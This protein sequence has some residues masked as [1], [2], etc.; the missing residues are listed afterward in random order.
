MHS[1]LTKPENTTLDDRRNAKIPNSPFFF[2]F[3]HTSNWKAHSSGTMLSLSKVQ[4]KKKG[5]YW[6]CPFTAHSFDWRKQISLLVW[7]YLVYPKKYNIFSIHQRWH[8]LL[9]KKDF[10]SSLQKIHFNSCTWLSLRNKTES[11]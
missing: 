5:S 11:S 9:Q 6:I 3:L 10:L 4:G 7:R 1:S 2:V 8:Y